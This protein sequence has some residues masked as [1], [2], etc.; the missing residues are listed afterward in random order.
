MSKVRTVRVIYR[1]EPDGWWA[2]S[3]DVPG[4]TAADNSLEGL[5][6]LVP[7]G[8]SSFLNEPVF[9]IEVGSVLEKG[10]VASRADAGQFDLT[11]STE[12]LSLSNFFVKRQDTT[13]GAPVFKSPGIAS[14]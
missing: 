5:R 7:E 8:I 13:E 9:V 1:E 2:E 4:Y 3:P 6:E 12:A 10:I 11:K 14:V